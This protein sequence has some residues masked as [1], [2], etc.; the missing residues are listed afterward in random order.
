MKS[1]T[2][3]ASAA[4]A[5]QQPLVIF[6]PSPAAKSGISAYVGELMPYLMADFDVTLVIA[7]DAR[8]PEDI[9]SGARILLSTEFR[10]HRSV[11]ESAP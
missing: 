3:P 4:G 1:E 8:L 2:V 6:A 11:F 10:R 5:P 7:D 9:E